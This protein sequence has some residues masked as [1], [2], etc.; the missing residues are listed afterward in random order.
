MSYTE[1]QPKC[2]HKY[3]YRAKSV[4]VDDRFKKVRKYM[5]VDLSA[6]ELKQKELEMD[7]SRMKVCRISEKGLL[8]TRLWIISLLLMLLN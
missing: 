7:S 4:R 3:Y 1:I 2:G 5:G 8:I 6:D